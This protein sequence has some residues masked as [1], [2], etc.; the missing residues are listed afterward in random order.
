MSR[1]TIIGAFSQK[2]I[3][4]GM[5]TAPDVRMMLF[6]LAMSI[7]A[8]DILELGYDA[9]FTTEVLAMTGV[10]VVGVD[11]NAEYPGIKRAAQRRLAKYKNCTLITREALDFLEASADDSYDLVFVD[12]WHDPNHVLLEVE[13]IRRIVRVGGIVVFHDTT[14][15]KRLGYVVKAGLPGWEI[16]HLP[17]WGETREGVIMDFGITVARK[18]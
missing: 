5:N 3:S 6:A 15:D 13:Q 11:N 8:Q 12:D 9:G 7:Y 16:L 1:K 14:W 17:A 18:V 2:V 4:G 10:R